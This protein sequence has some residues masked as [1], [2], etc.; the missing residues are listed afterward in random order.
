VLSGRGFGASAAGKIN[1][2]VINFTLPSARRRYV[3][4]W[5]LAGRM[6]W[7]GI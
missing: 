7:E 2:T 4:P 5:W 1:R 6:A 3:A